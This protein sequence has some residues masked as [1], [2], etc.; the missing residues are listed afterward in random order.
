[1][2]RFSCAAV[3]KLD[4]DHKKYEFHGSPR[5]WSGETIRKKIMGNSSLYILEEKVKLNF[6]FVSE[7]L[8]ALVS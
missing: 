1:M 8:N 4:N 5:V 3:V 6:N 7:I 2:F